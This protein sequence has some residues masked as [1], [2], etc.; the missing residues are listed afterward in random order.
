MTMRSTSR[1]ST[2]LALTLRARRLTFFLI[3][4]TLT[5]LAQTAPPTPK[6]SPD[7]VAGIPVN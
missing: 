5:L 3:S 7:L 4:G 1:A 2:Q 6:P